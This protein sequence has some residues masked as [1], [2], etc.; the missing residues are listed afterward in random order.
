MDWFEA[1]EVL[2]HLDQAW[3]WVGFFLLYICP[4][5]QHLFWMNNM[6]I[7]MYVSTFNGHFHVFCVY[8]PFKSR[9]D[10]VLGVEAAILGPRLHLLRP[11][12]HHHGRVLPQRKELSDIIDK[13]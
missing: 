9:C 13:R 1:E 6:A 5:M 7:S 8:S 2:E 4:S 3:I 11:A 12:E 10:W